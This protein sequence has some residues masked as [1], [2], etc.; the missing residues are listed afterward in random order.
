MNLELKITPSVAV[1]A[2]KGAEVLL[3]KHREGASHLT[4]V[5]GLPGGRVEE[6]ESDE[7]RAAKEFK[8][9]TGLEVNREDLINYPNNIYHASIERK[10]GEVVNFSW[11]VFIARRFTGELQGSDE[12]QPEWVRTSALDEYTLLPNVKRAIEDG[13][14]FLNNSESRVQN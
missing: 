5:Y 11:R 14:N 12:T 7:D 3:V 10:G 13:L 2:Y 1:L 6:N 9:E 4:N 8:E